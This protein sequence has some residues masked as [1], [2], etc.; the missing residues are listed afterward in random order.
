MKSPAMSYFLTYMVI[1][2]TFFSTELQTENKI[3]VKRGEI[4]KKLWC[5]VSVGE[6]S[7]ITGFYQMSW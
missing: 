5:C 3:Y 1:R 6:Y 2:M 4:L 7:K